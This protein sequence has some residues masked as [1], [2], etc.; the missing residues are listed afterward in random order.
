MHRSRNKE[1]LIG[2]CV[3]KAEYTATCQVLVMTVSYKDT[4]S[5]REKIIF[6]RLTLSLYILA[7]H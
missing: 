7:P 2:R 3:R 5:P 6:L 1:G 4:L